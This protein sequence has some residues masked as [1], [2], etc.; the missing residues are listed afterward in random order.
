MPESVLSFETLAISA[1]LTVPNTPIRTDLNDLRKQRV[2]R[3]YKT[4]T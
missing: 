1:K 3:G 2:F 4:G